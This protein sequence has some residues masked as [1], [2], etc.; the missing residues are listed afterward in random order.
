MIRRNRLIFL[1]NRVALFT[2]YEYADLLQNR[3][4]LAARVARVSGVEV[5][6]DE[7]H[8]ELAHFLVVFIACLGISLCDTFPQKLFDGSEYVTS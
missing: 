3:G 5:L 4:C 8:I 6:Q 2:C 7:H 1:R